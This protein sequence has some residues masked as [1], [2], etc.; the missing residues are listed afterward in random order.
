MIESRKSHRREAWEAFQDLPWKADYINSARKGR[1]W[2]ASSKVDDVTKVIVFAQ[3][4]ERLREIVDAVEPG[5]ADLRAPR[6]K[7]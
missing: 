2:S 6:G 4:L 3:S 1:V 7:S 5:L